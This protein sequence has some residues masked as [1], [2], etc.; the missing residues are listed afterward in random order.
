MVLPFLGETPLHYAVQTQ[1]VDA[2]KQLLAQ[3][4]NCDQCSRRLFKGEFEPVSADYGAAPLHL[5]VHYGEYEITKMLLEYGA[6]PSVT[7]WGTNQSALVKLLKKE[8]IKKINIFEFAVL[9]LSFNAEPAFVQIDDS[10]SQ[11]ES[12]LLFLLKIANQLRQGKRLDNLLDGRLKEPDVDACDQLCSL[13]AL[14]GQRVWQTFY[15]AKSGHAIGIIYGEEQQ[16][17]RLLDIPIE[18]LM[19]L[20]FG[21]SFSGS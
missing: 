2:V 11:C 8:V 5:A 7:T 9:L 10:V 20:R 19:F 17:M 21:H 3:N 15:A 13:H 4:V 16:A 1:Q 6:D 14:A 18:K 12:S